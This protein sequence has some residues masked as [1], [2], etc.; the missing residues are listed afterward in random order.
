M[1]VLLSQQIPGESHEFSG[2]GRP[3][4]SG[5]AAAGKLKNKLLF[6]FFFFLVRFFL[7]LFQLS[8]VSKAESNNHKSNFIQE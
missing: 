7:L 8:K 5:G 4:K 3:A 2:G 1:N 6:Y